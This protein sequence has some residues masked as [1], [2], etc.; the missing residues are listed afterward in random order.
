M[1]KINFLFAAIAIVFAATGVYFALE[2]VESTVPQQ[3]ASNSFFAQTFSD[4]QG[5]PHALSQWKGKILVVNF[6][7][8]WCPPCVEEMPE[9]VALQRE[10]GLH[11]VQVI[12]IGID[13]AANISAFSLKH[14][15]DYPLYIAGMNGTELSRQFGNQSG[16][17]PF[18][19]L[20]GTD[21][22]IK[23]T[24]LGRLKFIQ[25]RQDLASL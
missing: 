13:S 15:I 11:N 20:I 14:K 4:A 12:G 25:L 22:Q 7:A 2:R 16:G 17:L 5:R 19:V 10:M 6:W 18:T 1:K 21:G 24:Y 9:L 23:K 3:S 8:T